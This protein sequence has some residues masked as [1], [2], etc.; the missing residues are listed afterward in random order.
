MAFVAHYLVA[1]LADVCNIDIFARRGTIPQDELKVSLF[2]VP[3]YVFA[4]S[5]SHF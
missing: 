4:L 3:K 2:L 5:L 1:E